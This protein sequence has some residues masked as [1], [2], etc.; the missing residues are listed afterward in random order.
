MK[1]IRY[2]VGKNSHIIY[3]INDLYLVIQDIEEYVK[4]SYNSIIKKMTLLKIDK[5]LNWHLTKENI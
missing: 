4:N 2:S 5:V 1:K 3:L